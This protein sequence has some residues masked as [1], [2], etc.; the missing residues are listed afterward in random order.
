[1]VWRRDLY[2]DTAL[3]FGLRSAPKIFAAVADAL[4][5]ILE[6]RGLTWILKYLDDILTIGAPDTEERSSNLH[7]ITYTCQELGL[8]LASEKL[9]GPTSKLT[10]QG[11]ELD[12]SAMEM[13]LPSDKLQELKATISSWMVRKS[14]TNASYCH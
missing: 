14:A 11:I 7:T 10:F 3:P 1:M 8:P 9:E 13:R 12:S 5:W 2:V 4:A 6:R